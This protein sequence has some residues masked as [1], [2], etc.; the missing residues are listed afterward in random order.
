[1][2]DFAC[3]LGSESFDKSVLVV[4]IRRVP[5]KHPNPFMLRYTLEK[6]FCYVSAGIL[7]IRIIEAPDLV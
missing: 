1:M 2:S 6:G 4:R 7:S 3:Y 5:L